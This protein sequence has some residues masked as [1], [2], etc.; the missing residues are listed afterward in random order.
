MYSLKQA[1]EAAGRGKPAILRAI[2]RG[3]VSAQRNAKNEWMIEPSE[4]HRVYPRVT[5]NGADGNEN[6]RDALSD[7]TALL[8][9][10]NEFLKQQIEREREIARELSRRLDDEATERR[11][12]TAIL[13]YK[14]ETTETQQEIIPTKKEGLFQRLLN[15]KS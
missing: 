11:K 5:R 3:L 2:Q 1:A 7:E 14:P 15:M 8:R 13:T 4:L 12:L 10:E 9:Q 6:E